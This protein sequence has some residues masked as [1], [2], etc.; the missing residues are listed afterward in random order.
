M[1]YW[2]IFD[3]VLTLTLQHLARVTRLTHLTNVLIV[4]SSQMHLC[5]SSSAMLTGYLTLHRKQS[6]NLF[7]LHQELKNTPERTMTC[8]PTHFLRGLEQGFWFQTMRGI[9]RSHPL[10]SFL[11]CLFKKGLMVTS[12]FPGEKFTF[13]VVTAYLLDLPVGLPFQEANIH[14]VQ[15]S[16]KG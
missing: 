4:H 16:R 1:G 13:L 15:S 11:K 2:E 8:M 7:L 6:E 12:L 5:L 9:W 10:Y 14:S 3:H